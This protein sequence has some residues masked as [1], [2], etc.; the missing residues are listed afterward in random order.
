MRRTF[1]LLL[2]SL[3][4]SVGT[5]E[6][7]ADRHDNGGPRQEQRDHGRKHSDKR[8]GNDKKG[9]PGK[10]EKHNGGKHHDKKSPKQRYG[11]PG[12]SPAHHAAPPKHGRPGG[13]IGTPPPPPMPPKL[14]PMVSRLT[15]GCHDVNVWQI[16]HDTY[17]VKYR[18][19]NRHY[20]RR[21]YPYADRYDNASLISVNW[22]PLS[23]WTLIPP[24]QLNINL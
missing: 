16:D 17:I 13:H 7:F 15:R 11:K 20:T 24:I 12:I 18:K 9:K 8:K 19:G 3:F 14:S 6:A 1:I 5:V 23:P 2:T 10:K 22:Q 4:L 21:I